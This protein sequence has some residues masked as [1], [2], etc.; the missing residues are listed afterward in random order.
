MISNSGNN[1]FSD[2]KYFLHGHFIHH[3][4]PNSRIIISRLTYVMKYVGLLLEYRMLHPQLF[5]AD[6]NG[7]VFALH[8]Y[9]RHNY[10]DFILYLHSLYLYFEVIKVVQHR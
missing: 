6:L 7:F 4:F 1:L 10:T 3:S 2:G 5:L 9:F 8:K